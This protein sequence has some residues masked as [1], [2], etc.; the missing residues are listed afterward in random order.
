MIKD[1]HNPPS[2][3]DLQYFLE[4][5]ELHSLT[6][7]SQRLGITQPTLTQVLKRLESHFGVLLFHRDKKGVRPTESASTLAQEAIDLMSRWSEIKKLVT[8]HEKEVIGVITLGAHEAVADYTLPHF[9]RELVQGY[10]GLEIRIK[11]GLSREITQDIISHKIDIGLVINPIRHLDLIIRP[12]F[13]DKVHFWKPK[14][15][16]VDHDI[17]ICQPQ[18]LQTQSL[19][20]KIERKHQF[21]KTLAIGQLS[22]IARL[23]NQGV[24]IGI[25]PE[26]VVQNLATAVQLEKM[27]EQIHF[28]DRL[29]LVTH[30]EKRRLQTIKTLSQVIEQK[31]RLTSV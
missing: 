1:S 7:A 10:P 15:K 21:K 23:V 28:L 5:Y 4:V 31:L 11:N 6:K 17:L 29:C 30:V 8:A 25:I 9:L 16:T 22:T 13:S 26:R 14:N 3:S 24:G 19:I 27:H 18:L 2:F 20:K 12:L